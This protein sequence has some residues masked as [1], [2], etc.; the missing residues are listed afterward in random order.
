MDNNEDAKK[1]FKEY[2]DQNPDIKKAFKET[3]QELK[4]PENI[5]KMVDAT[6]PYVEAILKL[7]DKKIN[8]EAESHR[9]ENR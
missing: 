1:R 4:K 7:R 3:I 9:K 6:T 5:Q 8:E 2:L